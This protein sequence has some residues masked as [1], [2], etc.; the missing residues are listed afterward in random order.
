MNGTIV[1]I[2]GISF[3]AYIAGGSVLLMKQNWS[4]Q[5]L[6]AMT[7]LSAGLLLS[8][9]LLDLIPDTLT[10]YKY[11]GWFVMLGFLLMYFIH[12]SSQRQENSFIKKGDDPRPISLS[13]LSIGMIVHNLFEGLSMGISYAVNF[14]FGLLVTVALLLHKIPEGLT[15]SSVLV[16]AKISSKK[17]FGSLVL[18]GAFT[19][20][21]A[22]GAI[23]LSKLI[24]GNS[25][26]IS[27]ALSLVAGIFLY[28]GGT[29]LLPSLNG[30][31]YRAIPIMFVGAILVY[32]VLHTFAEAFI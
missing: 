18:Q 4:K 10:E 31:P 9:A 3:F 2:V 22:F 16:S 17:I 11:S 14:Q 29:T 25:A 23:L 30:R 19:W 8:L 13:I 32:F 24:S 20:I 21:G 12:L 28:L 6:S 7:A 5:Q 1:W 27:I 26:I 15:V